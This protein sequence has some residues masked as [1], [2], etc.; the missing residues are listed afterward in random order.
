MSVVEFE[1]T[2]TDV[3]HLRDVS[4]KIRELPQSKPEVAD[5]V[6]EIIESV[7]DGGDSS[8]IELIERYDGTR[9][10]SSSLSVGQDEMV[11]AL[12]ELDYEVRQAIELAAKNVRQVA[13][14]GMT[15]GDV[16]V[17]IDQGQKVTKRTVPV[18]KAAAYVPG[19]RAPYPSTVVMTCVPAS[20]AGVKG[21]AICSPADDSGRIPGSILAAAAVCG[22]DKAYLMGGAHAIAALATGTESV[23]PVDVIVGPGNAYVQEAKRQLFGQVGV[24]SIAGPSELMVIADADCDVDSVAL[25]LLAQSEHGSDSLLVLA[26]PDRKVLDSVLGK[27]EKLNESSRSATNAPLAVV[28]TDTNESALKFSEELAPEHLELACSDHEE[29]SRTVSR[30]GCVLIG[31]NGAAA[32]ADYVAG[33]NHVLPTGGAARFSSALSPSVFTRTMSIVSIPDDSVEGIA[34]PATILA[35]TEGFDIHAESMLNRAKQKRET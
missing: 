20:V 16:D 31:R 4:Q 7:K 21:I 8:L 27:M 1:I 33:S 14:A 28:K 34:D 2:S 3:S 23:E 35:R 18:R 29:I 30:S 10:D 12:E 26:G 6:A 24:D 17:V 9:V 13:E 25:D 32:F 22:V 5:R 11:A 15:S 19:G